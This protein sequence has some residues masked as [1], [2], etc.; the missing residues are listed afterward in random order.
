MASKRISGL[1]IFCASAR[2]AS[3]FDIR[4]SV[5]AYTSKSYHPRESGN[6][7]RFDQNSFRMLVLSSATPSQYSRGSD[8]DASFSNRLLGNSGFRGSVSFAGINPLISPRLFSSASEG[9]GSIPQGTDSIAESGSIGTGGSNGGVGGDDWIEKFK[10]VWHS[11]VDAVKYT[12]EKA[13]EASNEA[14]PHVQLWLDGHP[15]LRDVIVPVGGTLAGTLLAWSLLPRLFRRFHKYSVEGPGALL[16]RSSLWGP[17]PYEKS[18]WG[19]LEVPV[20]YFIIFMAFLQMLVHLY[21]LLFPVG[22]YFGYEGLLYSGGT[23]DLFLLSCAVVKWLR[24]LLLPHSMLH[25]LGRVLLLF[26]LS[27]FCT[28]GKQM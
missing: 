9:K 24:Q 20:R 19:A 28:G 14:S 12:G 6:V 27:G 25:R 8:F 10:E 23:F 3:R 18:F 7:H 21:L 16:A 4:P 17:V 5:A 2:P 15:Y 11:T 1:K 13:K 22:T 26:H